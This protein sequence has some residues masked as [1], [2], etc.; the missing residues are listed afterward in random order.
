MDLPEKTHQGWSD[1]VTGRKVYAL[2]SLAAKMV[3]DRLTRS[4]QEDPSAENIAACIDHLYD[5]FAANAHTPSVQEDLKTI[6]G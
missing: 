3:L 6:F 5:V 2:K 4:V 1:I